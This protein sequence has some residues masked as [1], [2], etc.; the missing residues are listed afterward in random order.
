MAG[1]APTGPRHLE[2]QRRVGGRGEA[3]VR[4]ERRA[5]LEAAG[6][7]QLALPGVR[8]APQDDARPVRE[9]PVDEVLAYNRFA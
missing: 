5:R 2:R 6:G 3:E 4:L 9:R 1:D 7:A 8:T